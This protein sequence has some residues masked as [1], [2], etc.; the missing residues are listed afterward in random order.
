MQAGSLEIGERLQT[1]SGDVKVVQ[2]KLPRPG[3][4]PVFNLEVH[5]EHVYFVGEDGVLVH[6]AKSYRGPSI[7]NSGQG[8]LTGASD[9]IVVKNPNGPGTT[10]IKRSQVAGDHTLPQEAILLARN[11]AASRGRS[12]SDDQLRRIDAITDSRQNL[13]PMDT[14]LN[15]SKGARNM[16]QWAGTGLG[17]ETSASYRAGISRTQASV[18]SKINGI[19]NEGKSGRP[20]NFFKQFFSGK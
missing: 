6:N 18:A 17:S 11:N 16:P 8:H 1:L 13:K 4:Q 10:T 3:P 20:M 2:Q 5:D 19:L 14:I 15:S 7:E 12:L 9:N